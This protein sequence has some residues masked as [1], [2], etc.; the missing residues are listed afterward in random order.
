MSKKKNQ[1]ITPEARQ[2]FDDVSREFVLD[3]HHLA[4]LRLAADCID[5]IQY[6]KKVL[7]AD[8]DFYLDKF[9]YPKP[10]PALRTLRDDKVTFARLLRELRLEPEQDIRL[11][12]GH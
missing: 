5:R 2:L 4:T 9:G 7:A 11:P 12:R 8:G 6:A 10:H 3:P 1:F